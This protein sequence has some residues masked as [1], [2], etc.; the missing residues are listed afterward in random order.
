LIVA[1]RL[2]GA[3]RI[4][5]W[6]GCHTPTGLSQ[7]AGQILKEYNTP[8]CSD[9]RSLARPG[10][11]VEDGVLFDDVPAVVPLCLECNHKT[12][13]VDVSITERKEHSIDDCLPE[14]H[15]TGSNLTGEILIEIFEVNVCDAIDNV[16][17]DRDRISSGEREMTSVYAK[18]DGALIKNSLNMMI[19][20]DRHAPMGV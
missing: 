13:Y 4:V 17:G 3:T 19:A 20:Y 14:S 11:R 8:A 15:I 7:V 16:F 18:I 6:K 1:W 10:F 2:C 9:H 12:G 5:N